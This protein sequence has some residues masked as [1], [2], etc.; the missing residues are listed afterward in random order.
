[1]TDN[2]DDD[3]YLST[4]YCKYDDDNGCDDGDGADNSD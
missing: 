2:D 1:M 3:V 4:P